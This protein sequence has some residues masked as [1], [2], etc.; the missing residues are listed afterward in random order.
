MGIKA[1]LVWPLY[2]SKC[3]IRSLKTSIGCNTNKTVQ[4]NRRKLNLRSPSPFPTSHAT[5]HDVMCR[6]RWPSNFTDRGKAMRT[7]VLDPCFH[8]DLR[9]KVTRAW[10]QNFIP[11]RTLPGA[12]ARGSQ[13]EGISLVRV[14]E[15]WKRFYE[16]LRA[17]EL[18]VL[19]FLSCLWVPFSN[20][21]NSKC[22]TVGYYPG[23]T[24][25]WLLAR[26]KFPI[27]K[28]QSLEKH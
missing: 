26:Y 16:P 10:S 3:L 15:K 21:F 27:E 23:T 8:R 28:I 9:A 19:G 22:L 25:P 6:A 17:R 11:V 5:R 14:W 7:S 18:L 2:E 20:I 13:S 4:K 24:Q 12:C 1:A